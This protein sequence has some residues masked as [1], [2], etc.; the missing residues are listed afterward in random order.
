MNL[1]YLKDLHLKTN[2]REALLLKIRNDALPKQ[3]GRADDME[4]LVVVIAQEREFEAVL[5]RVESDGAWACRS[6]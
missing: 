1:P 3:C 2:L 5:S 4:H 6:V